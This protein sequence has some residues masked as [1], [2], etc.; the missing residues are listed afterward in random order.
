MG[1]YVTSDHHFGHAN[2]IDYCDRPFSSVGEMNTALL[3]R[4]YETVT[5]EDVLVHPGDVAMDMQDGRETVEYYRGY[6]GPIVVELDPP[7]RM[8]AVVGETVDYLR[9][10][11]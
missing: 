7:Y 11:R 4:Y 5:T 10:R 9:E 3:D 6:R 1:R 8:A 2:I